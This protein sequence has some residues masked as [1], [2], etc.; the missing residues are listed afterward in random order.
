MI[1]ALVSENAVVC[2][3]ACMLVDV[4]IGTGS[5]LRLFLVRS[6]HYSELYPHSCFEHVKIII[7]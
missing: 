3:S 6:F 7:I 2:F 5:R 4:E 1:A